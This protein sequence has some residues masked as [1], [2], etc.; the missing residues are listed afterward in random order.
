MIGHKDFYFL[1]ENTRFVREVQYRETGDFYAE[2]TIFTIFVK[3]RNQQEKKILQHSI[4][5]RYV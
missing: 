5:P 4:L 1:S 3:N 2:N